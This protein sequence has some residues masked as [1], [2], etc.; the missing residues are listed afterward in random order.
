MPEHPTTIPE[1]LKELHDDELSTWLRGLNVRIAE[2]RRR[3]NAALHAWYKSLRDAAELE[4]HRRLG[5]FVNEAP[6]IRGVYEAAVLLPGD[7]RTHLMQSY[8]EIATGNAAVAATHPLAILAGILT[9]I[10]NGVGSPP[11]TT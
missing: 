8:D 4:K 2:E 10:L 7:V 9:G 1:C 5:Q 3:Q 11:T 6:I